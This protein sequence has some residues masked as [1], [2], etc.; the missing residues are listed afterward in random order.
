MFRLGSPKVWENLV[1][2]YNYIY[3]DSVCGLYNGLEVKE[4]PNSEDQILT[5]SWEKVDTLGMGTD[6]PGQGKY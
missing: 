1:L 4:V 6:I 5:C 3:C 2:T